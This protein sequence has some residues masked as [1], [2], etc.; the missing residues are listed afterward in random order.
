MSM[1]MHTRAHKHI[2]VYKFL[3][4]VH[5]YTVTANIGLLAFDYPCTH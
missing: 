4:I 5:W 3:Q 2:H 1:Q